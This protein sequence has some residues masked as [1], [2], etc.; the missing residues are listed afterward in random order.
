MNELFQRPANYWLRHADR[1][2]QSGDLVRAA[3]LQRHAVHAQPDSEAAHA[4][5]A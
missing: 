1:H 2:R 4:Q 5:Y 3:V